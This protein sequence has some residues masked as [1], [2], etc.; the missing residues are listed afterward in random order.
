M[1][2]WNQS[3][4]ANDPDAIAAF[5]EPDWVFVGENGIF[6]GQQFLEAVATGQVSHDFMASEVHD[7]RVYGDVAIVIARVRNRGEFE[8]NP[9]ALDE[10]ST[11]VFVRRGDRW[12]CAVTHL[13]S[14]AATTPA[15]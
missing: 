7:V 13:T 2:D 9:F 15:A 10:W 5:A 14:V 8:G 1:D 12:R 4:V 6:P 11:D 3:V